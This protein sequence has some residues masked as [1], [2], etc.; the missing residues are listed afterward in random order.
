MSGIQYALTHETVGDPQR[1]LIA[2]R[3]MLAEAQADY[4]HYLGI[5]VQVEELEPDTPIEHTS[6]AAAMYAL[7]LPARGYAL[8]MADAQAQR[9]ATEALRNRLHD[10][11]LRMHPEWSAAQREADVQR[12]MVGLEPGR[13]RI[14]RLM[15]GTLFTITTRAHDQRQYFEKAG[16]FNEYYCNPFSR[17][18]VVDGH[19]VP[20][21]VT[22]SEAARATFGH[23][24]T[25]LH[26]SDHVEGA[27]S[28]PYRTIASGPHGGRDFE[29]DT[30]WDVDRVMSHHP[31]YV[32]RIN[33]HPVDGTLHLDGKEALVGMV[34]QQDTGRL[35][36]HPEIP[37]GKVMSE[38][39]APPDKP[40]QDPGAK[41]AQE[42]GKDPEPDKPDDAPGAKH[43]IAPSKDPEPDKP[44]DP[45]GAKDVLEHDKDG[46]AKLETSH[47]NV[48]IAQLPESVPPQPT[49]EHDAP[50]VLAQDDHDDDHDDDD[51]YA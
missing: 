46:P 3:G 50:V 25:V 37:A 48:A 38:W 39:V 33:Y 21:L 12:R 31:D 34:S 26:E 47:T 7:G 17:F 49:D 23:A 22:T 10:G 36:S 43:P 2:T 20:A 18:A 16:G 27:M 9:S 5:A 15:E 45:P 1:L 13:R 51:P 29:Q 42:P 14:A 44:A 35:L 11:V 4:L 41:D 28:I 6:A 8:V 24:L 19:A 30:V 40:D 32:A